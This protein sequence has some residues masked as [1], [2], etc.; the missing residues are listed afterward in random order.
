MRAVLARRDARLYIAGQALSSFGDSAMWLALG[1]WVKTL[2]GSSAAAGLVMFAV[3]APQLAAPAAGLLVDRV[4]RRPLL[5]AANL[6]TGTAV[7][8]LLAVH[9]PDQLWLLYAVAVVYGSSYTILASGQ[10]ALLVDL[11]PQELLAD[12]N[13]LLQ[14]LRE[15]QR[16]VAPLV[17]AGLFSLVGGGPVAA[18]DAATFAT[19]AAALLAIRVHE[20][21]PEAWSAH[22]VNAALAG[23]RHLARTVLL[24][25][26]LI[27]C[28]LTLLVVGFSESLMFAVVDQGLHDAAS[29]VGV[30]MA[31]QGVGAVAG[32]LSAARVCRHTG[33]GVLVGVGM[34]V[35]AGSALLL[36]SAT[37]PVVLIGEALLGAALPWMVVGVTTLLQRTTPT[38]L[39]GRAYSAADMLLAA[40]QTLSIATGA[41]LLGV[42]DYRTL[43]LAEAAVAAG[44]STY[45]LT[46][47]EQRAGSK[48]GPRGT[49]RPAF[50]VKRP[51]PDL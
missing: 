40:P 28:A 13:G 10:S 19:A 4:R 17:G 36:A 50:S 45:L 23:A 37:V 14:T 18:I 39:L 41:A 26:V 15:S 6:A 38:H 46:R 5:V 44:A 30:L 32:A 8:A 22:P 27:A 7:L 29:F 33:E 31:M 51:E 35:F 12:A 47:P 3:V 24:R 25:Q 11:L 43:L 2:T 1:I 20:R 21:S 49:P 42:A 16:L 34:A 48:R 9:G